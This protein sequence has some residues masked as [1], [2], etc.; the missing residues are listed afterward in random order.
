MV[1]QSGGYDRDLNLLH[2]INFEYAV[3]NPSI[4]EWSL[5]FTSPSEKIADPRASS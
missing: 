5:I 2:E 1:D 3:Q 4:A